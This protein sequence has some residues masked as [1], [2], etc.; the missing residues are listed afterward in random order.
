MAFTRVLVDDRSIYA[1]TGSGLL[2]WYRDELR[3][4]SNDPPPGRDR[5]RARLALQA[6][7]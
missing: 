2:L 7:R 5:T 6:Q 4:G 3:D 1:I